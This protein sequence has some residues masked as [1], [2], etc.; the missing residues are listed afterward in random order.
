MPST[1]LRSDH[2]GSGR[3]SP[4]ISFEYYGADRTYIKG[5]MRTALFAKR[6]EPWVAPPYSQRGTVEHC[7]LYPI[8]S[9]LDRN[10]DLVFDSVGNI[11][12]TAIDFL[13]GDVYEITQ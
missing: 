11:Y 6:D 5:G 7:A 13:F 9:F 12:G 4:A 8:P 10:G 1:C 2:F 3:Q